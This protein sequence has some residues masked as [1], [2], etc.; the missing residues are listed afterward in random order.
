[1]HQKVHN[2]ALSGDWDRKEVYHFEVSKL[3]TDAATEDKGDRAW[4]KL[5]RARHRPGMVTGCC[6]ARPCV[7]PPHAQGQ[8][9]RRCSRR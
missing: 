3:Y 6:S 7:E 9:E 2:P 1:M 8:D 4:R 5:L